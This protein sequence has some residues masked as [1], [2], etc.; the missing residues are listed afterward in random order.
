MKRNLILKLALSSVVVG[1]TTTGCAS[2]GFSTAHKVADRSEQNAAKNAEKAEKYLAKGKLDKALSY[3]EMAVEGQLSNVDYRMLLARTYMANGLYTS[4][5]RTL[6]DVMELGQVDPR[7]VI[8]LALTRLAQ[9]KADSAK[10]LLEA[11][12]S[13]I[14]ASDYGLALAIAGDSK[15]AVEILGQAIRADNSDARV[16]QNLALAYAMDGRWREARLMASQDL[17]QTAADQRIAEWA[18]IARPGAYSTRV[19]SLL[20]VAPREDSGQP[21]RLALQ[22]AMVPA[23]SAVAM[24]SPVKSYSQEGELAAVGP[25]VRDASNLLPRAME[26][27]VRVSSVEIPESKPAMISAP[28]TPVKV[29]AVPVQKTTAPAVKKEPVKLAL[30]DTT[31]NVGRTANGGYMVQLGAFSSTNSANSAWSHYQAKYGV[32]KGFDPA[33]STINVKG[34]SLVR[35]AAIGFGNKKTADDVCATIKAKGGNCIV[36]QAPQTAEKRF[37]SNGGAKIAARK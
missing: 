17:S 31:R 11:H 35:L 6:M 32:L 18:Q 3:A 25:A 20:G 5:E 9:N 13:I 2:L 19:A 22:G 14:P 12:R 37:A 7:T 28:S 23:N 27:D 29:A 1:M 33:S 21:V 36:R 34:K 4:A 15:K 8:S 26:N 16:R 30:A 10:S 24:N